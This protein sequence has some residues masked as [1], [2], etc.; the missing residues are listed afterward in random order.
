MPGRRPRPKN[1]DHMIIGQVVGPHGI[2]GGLRVKVLTDFP[3]R[4]DK[5]RTVFIDG[6]PC[7]I[8][9]SF[10]HKD[11]VRLDLKEITNRNRAEELKWVGVTIPADDL[12][13]TDED[14]F[15][16]RDLI[17]L[18]VVTA[19]GKDL[20]KVEDV[21][22]N[23]AHDLLVMGEVLIPVVKAFIASIDL[24]SEVITVTLIPGMLPEDEA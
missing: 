2:R 15:L 8:D 10:W 9:R 22:P 18:K 13:E 21:M 5:G 14:E 11:Q 6:E 24:E 12:P 1:R 7:T 19:E 4:F 17:G 3:E 20:G 23:P 16:V